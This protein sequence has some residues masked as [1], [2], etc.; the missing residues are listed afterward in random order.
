MKVERIG[1]MYEAQNIV[2][3]AV[4]AQANLHSKLSPNGAAVAKT[5]LIESAV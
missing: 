2:C 3:P 1:M 4:S 5:T